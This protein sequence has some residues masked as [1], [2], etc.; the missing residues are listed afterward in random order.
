MLAVC[1]NSKLRRDYWQGYPQK[2]F[3]GGGQPRPER[4]VEHKEGASA[5]TCPF[6]LHTQCLQRMVTAKCWRMDRGQVMSTDTGASLI[7]TRPVINASL[8]ERAKQ[9][10]HPAYGFMKTIPIL[11]KALFELTL[12]QCGVCHQDCWWVYTRPWC[13]CGFWL[14]CAMTGQWST[15]VRPGGVPMHP[16]VWRETVRW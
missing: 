1:G 8:P 14:L 12:W 11:K 9:T 16:S 3:L 4:W 13:I 10:T 15:I 2:D 7:V 6:S 5:T